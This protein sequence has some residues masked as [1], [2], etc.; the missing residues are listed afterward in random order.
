MK[1]L[2]NYS[3]LLVMALLFSSCGDTAD[4][5]TEGVVINYPD[6]K[7]ELYEL[8]AFSLAPYQINALIYLP[9]ET[10][11]IGAATIPEVT[12]ELGGWK[13][14]LKL[15]QKFQM[16]II[17]WGEENGVSLHKEELE[18]QS[19]MY[20]IEYIEDTEDFIYYKRTL[21]NEGS[22]NS[23]S[24]VGVQHV[25]YHCLGN[26]KIEGINYL[27]RTVELGSPKPI[28]EYIKVSVKNVEEV[29]NT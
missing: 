23:N 4:E 26:H 8:E 29:P 27:F 20:D 13:W 5:T 3:L 2:L 21:K 14:G 18:E 24:N 15:G 11:N 28:T 6:E 1:S 12:H 25:S 19:H 22:E 10:A 16:E 9:D 17:D 7:E